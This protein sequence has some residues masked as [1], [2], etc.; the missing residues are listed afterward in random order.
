MNIRIDPAQGNTQA[1]VACPGCGWPSCRR[2]GCYV[3]KGFHAPNR[4]MAIPI[5]VPRYRCCNPDCA[6]RTFSI[7]PPFVMPYCRFYWFYLLA[8]RDSWAG[9]K[10]SYHL[11]R[12]VW[13]VG[14]VVI[15]RAIA[16]LRQVGAWIEELHREL[17]DGWP[18]RQLARMVKFITAKLGRIELVRRWY[19]H[20]YPLRLG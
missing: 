5:K 18:T 14:R 16:L 2:H 15:V 17:T 4:A 8:L 20:R 9:G 12:H 10:T 7:L 1:Q 19:H 3:R 13:H 6:R 11:A